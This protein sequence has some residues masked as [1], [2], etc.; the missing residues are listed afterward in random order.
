MLEKQ[1]KNLS[2]NLDG[3]QLNPLKGL[4]IS[5]KHTWKRKLNT[6][7]ATVRDFHWAPPQLIG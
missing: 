7:A 4:A 3:G 6:N 5:L 2:K 1:N